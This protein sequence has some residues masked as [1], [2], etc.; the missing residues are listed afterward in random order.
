D[1]QEHRFERVWLIAVTNIDRFGGGMRITPDASPDDGYAD[2]C[3]VSGISRFRFL[4]AFPKVYKGTHTR[5]KAV[6]L[7]RCQ[8]VRIESDKPLTMQADGEYVGETPTAIELQ[9]TMLNI[10]TE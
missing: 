2:I 10:I 5:L 7:Y 1:G 3:I 8:H 6:H 4:L 9:S